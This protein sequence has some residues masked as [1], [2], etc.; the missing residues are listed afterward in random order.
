MRPTS[1]L[2]ALAL[3]LLAAAVTSGC[4]SSRTPQD[5]VAAYGDALVADDPDAAWGLLSEE[6]QARTDLQSFRTA[7][8]AQRQS[9]LPLARDFQEAPQNPS[10]VWANLR[11]S[12]YDNVELK[13]TD[14]GWKI[15]RGVLDAYS[16]RTPQ[17]ALLSFV[18]ALDRRRYDVLLKLAP[19]QYARH[20]TPESLKADLDARQDELDQLLA[21]LQPHL[22]DPIE[23]RGDR[24]VLRYGPH[25][26]SFILEGDA[27]KIED[28]D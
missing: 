20:M 14:D 23:E 25:Q 17:E 5:T 18:R 2:A 11:W 6:V 13:L 7:W 16:Q 8:K 21:A 4:A 24:A 3:L 28:P 10:R 26:V 9:L 22:Q 15:T 12:S 19:S 1:R 27:W